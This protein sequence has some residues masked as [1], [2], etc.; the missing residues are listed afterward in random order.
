MAIQDR[1]IPAEDPHTVLA[2]VIETNM[3]SPD[4]TWTPIVNPNWLIGKKQ[5]TFQIAIQPIYGESDM[6][7]LGLGNEIAMTSRQFM[8]ITLFAPTRDQVWAL[9]T[10]LKLVL[11]DGA[12][13]NPLGTGGTPI[14]DY[15]YI[16]IRRTD[17]TKPVLISDPNCGPA[18]SDENCIGYRIDVSV[19]MR[20]EE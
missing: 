3:Q 5:K 2:K 7:T 20:W 16:I 15:H 8:Q 18:S 17:S 14:N 10:K 12:L 6:A 11:N 4:G 19:E 13:I 9:F 1:G